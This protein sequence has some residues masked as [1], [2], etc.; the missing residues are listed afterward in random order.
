MR[1]MRQKLVTVVLA[2][3]LAIGA[4]QVALAEKW[5]PYQFNGDERF[6]YRVIWAEDEEQKE[7]TYIL[8]I[9]KSGK[10]TEE[11]ED[12]FEVSYITRGM[13]RKED[14]GAESAFGLWGAYGISLNVFVLNPT[15]AFFFSQM[16]LKV[17]EKMSFF[18]AG[19]IKVTGKEKVAKREGFV[20]QLFQSEDDGE[21]LIAEWTIDPKLALPL[22]SKVFE[23]GKVQGQV[24]LIKYTQY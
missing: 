11:G 5:Q 17:G 4:W 2:V 19:T 6:E 3:L 7:A 23:E 13:L 18:G 9:K 14:L 16:E 1:R 10:K 21:E 24:E 22:R 20:C 15:Y 12:I 8:D